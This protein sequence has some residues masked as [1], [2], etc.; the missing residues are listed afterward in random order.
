MIKEM[1][2]KLKKKRMQ[3]KNSVN[4]FNTDIKLGRSDIEIILVKLCNIYRMEISDYITINE[5]CERIKLIDTY[6]IA[7]TINMNVLWNSSEQKVNKGLYYVIKNDDK[8][9]DEAYA[10]LRTACLK[11]NSRLENKYTDIGAMIIAD[12]VTR[13][14][15]NKYNTH[16]SFEKWIN[17]LVFEPMNL[18]NTMYNPNN[19][20]ITGNGNNRGVHDPKAKA[21]GGVSGHAGIFTNSSDLEKLARGIF[22]VNNF[23]RNKMNGRLHLTREQIARFGEITFPNAKQSNKEI[24][25]YM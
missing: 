7:D 18:K 15:N 12:V 23:A 2:N 16:Y 13:W 6:G 22:A 19:M 24:W 3:L 21:F 25:A 11:S 1:I 14:L 5:Y 10:I 8:D 9:R 4:C 20:N 17:D